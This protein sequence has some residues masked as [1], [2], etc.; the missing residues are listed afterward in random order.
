MIKKKYLIFSLFI[1]TTICFSQD[2]SHNVFATQGGASQVDNVSLEWTLGESIAEATVTLDGFYTQ[3]FNQPFLTTTRLD[4][5]TYKKSPFKIVLYPNP[6]DV[7]LHVYIDASQRTALYISMFD[8]KG[9]LIRHDKILGSDKD[10][11]LS[12]N[13]YPSGVYLLKF[14]NAEGVLIETHRIIKQ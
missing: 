8:V 6:V 9:K 10:V 12:L 7:L 13:N 1:I 4:V 3:G 5:E 14:S 2:L 11:T